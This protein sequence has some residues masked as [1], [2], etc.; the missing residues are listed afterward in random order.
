MFAFLRASSK[1][2]TSSKKAKHPSSFE[3][4]AVRF[5]SSAEDTQAVLTSRVEEQLLTLTTFQGF[6][7]G[8]A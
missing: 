1:A 7:L 2:F 5:L 4:G 3:A 6:F 8:L